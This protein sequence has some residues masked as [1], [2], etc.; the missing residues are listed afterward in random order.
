MCYQYLLKK[1]KGIILIPT[2]YRIYSSFFGKE[3]NHNAA[4]NLLKK[5]DKN[6]S[7]VRCIV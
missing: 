4:F 3:I 2:K 7:R 6:L 5:P 1:I